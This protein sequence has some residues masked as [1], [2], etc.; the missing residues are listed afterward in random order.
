MVRIIISPPAAREEDEG[1]SARMVS[2]IC[3]SVIDCSNP[4]DHCSRSR[5]VE[6]HYRTFQCG[7]GCGGASKLLNFF[8]DVAAAVASFHFGRVTVRGR[9]RLV[10][11]ESHGDIL[12][13]VAE[14]AI[15]K[16]SK[17]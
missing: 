3:A 7:G 5:R 15:R 6:L 13:V 9:D 14:R 10:R 17:P 4:L 16:G 11:R 1:G 8:V 12:T 2:G